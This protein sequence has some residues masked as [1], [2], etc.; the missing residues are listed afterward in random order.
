MAN[1]PLH[2]ITTAF[3]DWHR[4]WT[5]CRLT[6]LSWAEQGIVWPF[7]KLPAPDLIARNLNIMRCSLN[8]KVRTCPQLNKRS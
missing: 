8:V 5:D 6:F 2:W 1:V 4:F 3:R 7:Q